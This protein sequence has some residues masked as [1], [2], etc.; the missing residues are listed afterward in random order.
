MFP[1]LHGFG[2]IYRN[3]TQGRRGV[4]S[5]QGMAGQD[6]YDRPFYGVFSSGTR[7]NIKLL[8]ILLLPSEHAHSTLFS[9]FHSSNSGVDVIA[10]CIQGLCLGIRIQDFQRSMLLATAFLLHL[11]ILY[12]G[13]FCCF[14]QQIK[15]IFYPSRRLLSLFFGIFPIP[16]NQKAVNVYIINKSPF[17]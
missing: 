8:Y 2:L 16:V 4:H 13:I 11:T 9:L 12:M 1:T 15:Y 3:I 10:R 17:Q 6:C 7:I 14:S 5:R